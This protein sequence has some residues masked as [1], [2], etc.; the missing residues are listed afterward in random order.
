MTEHELYHYGVLGMKWG[1]RRGNTAKAYRKASK[2]LDKLDKK[3]AKYEQRVIKRAAKNDDVLSSRFASERKREKAERKVTASAASYRKSLRKANKW[4]K[5]MEKTF[6]KTDVRLTTEQ[7]KR[8]KKYINRLS[9]DALI[10][11]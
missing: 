1:V 9:M 10:H 7:V 3:V 8:G 5:S 6:A 4:Y 11:Y 2:K